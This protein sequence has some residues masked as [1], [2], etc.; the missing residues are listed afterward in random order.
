L[1]RAPRQSTTTT[2]PTTTT[3]T[4]TSKAIQYAG[5]T[6][7]IQD[8]TSRTKEEEP[9]VA[10]PKVSLAALLL[11]YSTAYEQFVM[12]LGLLVAAVAGLCFP[13]WL[14]LLVK[15]LDN[16]LNLGRII[17]IGGNVT[18][19]LEDELV[20]LVVAFVVLGAV[21]LVSG[22]TYVFLWTWVG[23]R[24]SRRIQQRFI[25]ACLRQDATW[26]D[27]NNR[28]ELPTVRTKIEKKRA[29]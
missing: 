27:L 22:F 26:F 11:S 3:T 17:S 29:K 1:P 16:M 13:A 9:K 19:L 28:D 6:Q 18:Q 21:S 12:V 5:L 14:I 20:K 25:R 7:W 2:T 10:V 24:Q 23:E 15:A 8:Q 4:T